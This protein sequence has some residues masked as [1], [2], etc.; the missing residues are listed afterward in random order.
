MTKKKKIGIF[1][2]LFLLLWFYFICRALVVRL[3]SLSARTEQ[4]NVWK[5]RKYEWI[6]RISRRNGITDRSFTLQRYDNKEIKIFVSQLQILLVRSSKGIFKSLAK[7]KK[8]LLDNRCD[9]SL[10][11][12]HHR[13]GQN[14]IL[15]GTNNAAGDVFR[16]NWWWKKS[17]RIGGRSSREIPEQLGET[18]LDGK[19]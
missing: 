18:E 11:H 12:R 3:N 17:W 2:F 14:R 5:Q 7:K 6:R 4:T 15:F 1:S 19:D 9:S 8:Y 16:Y 13:A 10:F